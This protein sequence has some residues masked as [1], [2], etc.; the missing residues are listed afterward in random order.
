MKLRL[1]STARLSFP[2]ATAI[3]VLLSASSAQAAT[4]YWD[5]NG[6][7]TAGSGAATGTWGTSVFW[8]TDSTGANVGSP[9]LTAT[10]INADDLFFSAG[11]NGTTGTVTVNGTQSAH[12]ITFDDAVAI[13][14]SGGTAINLGSATV[15]SGLSFTGNAANTISTGIILNSAATAVAISNSTASLQTIGTITGSATTGTQVL[16]VGSSSSGGITLNSIGD[17][18]AGGNVALTVNNSGAGFVT[19]SG[20]N[21]YTGTTTISAGTLQISSAVTNG[22]S[23]LS[24][25]GITLSQGATLL[26]NATAGGAQSIAAPITLSG[27]AGTASIK[28]GGN[29]RSVSLSGGITG[30]AGVSQTLAIATGAVATTSGDRDTFNFNGVIANG[31]SGG[32]LGVSID[33]A[34][35]S[36]TGQNAFVNLQGQNTF[37]GDLTVT[38]TKGMNGGSTYVGAWVTIGGQRYGVTNAGATNTVGQTSGTGFLGSGADYSGNISLSTGANT[39]LTTLSFLTSAN[40]ILRG[41]ISGGGAL[42]QDGTGSLTLTAAN[43]FTGSTTVTGGKI[44]M[45]NSLALENS[46]YVTTGSTGAIGLDVT[47][48]LSSGTLT[49]GGLS[50]SV[51]LATAI[52]GYTSV[53]NL[54][55]NPQGVQSN[56]YSGI[57]ANGSGNMALTK[58][59]LGNQVLSGANTYSGATTIVAGILNANSSSALGNGS[60]TNTLIFTGGTLQAGGAITSA[61]TRGVTLTSTGVIDT[62]TFAV[63]IAGNVTGAGDL[64]KNGTGTLTLSGTNN[65]GG[66]TTVNAGTLAFA[67]QASLYNSTTGSWTAANINVKPVATLAVNVDTTGTAGFTTANLNTLLANISVANTAAQG[68]QAGAILAIDTTAATF[69]QGNVIANSTG[70]FGGAIGLTKLGINTLVLDKANTYTGAT[71]ISAGTLQIGAGGTTGSLSTSSSIFNNGTLTINRS[72]AVVQGTDFSSAPITGTGAFIQNNATGTTTLN[73]AN[74]FTGTTTVS[75]GVLTLT[76][77]L[78]L[79]NSALVTTGAANSVVLSGVTT[80]TFG[81]LNGAVDLATFISGYNNVTALTLNPQSGTVTYSGIIANSGMT[82]TKTGAGT[83]VLS[84]A[85]TYS[86]ATIVNAGVLTLGSGANGSL[87]SLS[88]LQVGSG[89]TF[90]YARTGTGQ[91]LAGLTV[92]P[93]SGIINNTSGQVLTL[94]GITRAAGNGTMNFGTTTLG[95]I[96][97]TVGNVN[98]MIGPWATTGTTTTLRYA[99]GSADGTT[100]TNIT[101]LTGTTATA[102][103]LANV[104]DATANFE[105]SAAATTASNLTAN[106]LRYSGAAT[107]TAIGA[108]NSLTLNGLMNAGSAGPFVISGGAASGGLIIGSTN[109]LVIAAN[110]QATTISAVIANGGSAGRLVYSGG[111]T[112]TLSGNNTFSGGLVINAGTVSLNTPVTSSFDGNAGAG[113]ITVNTGGTLQITSSAITSLSRNMTLNGGIF[114]F[115][116]SGTALSYTGTL[117]LAANSSIS[118]GTNNAEV[119]SITGGTSGAGGLTK[120]GGGV[121]RLNGANTYTGPTVVSAGGLTVKSSLYGNDTSKWTPANI[122]VASGAALVLNVQGSGEFTMTQAA[123]MFSQ[124]ST[125]VNNNGLLAG[126]FIGVE[127]RNATAGTYVYSTAITDSTGSGGG[128]VGFKH[129]GASTTIVELTGANTYSGATIVDGNGTL[130]VSSLNSVF[131]NAALGTVHS[132]SSSLGA[133]TTVA[134]GTIHLG[135][136]GS[137]SGIGNTFSGGSITY[138]GTGET[139]DRVLSLNG[140]GGGADFYFLDQSGTG[141]LKF[142]SNFAYGDNRGNKTLNLQGSTGGT[143]ELANVLVNPSTNGLIINKLGTG[144]WTLSGANL[145]NGTTTLTGGLLQIGIDSTGSV[146][147]ITSGAIGTGGLTFNGGGLASNGVTARTIL[148]AVTFTGNATLGNATNTGKLTFSANAA[149]GN[150][151]RTLTVNS[152]AEFTGI[153]SS[154][155]A[156]GIIKAGNAIL[157]L[158]GTNTYSGTTTISAGILNANSSAALGSGVASNTLIFNGGTLQAGGTITSAS[159]RG[160]TMTGAGTIDTNSNAVSIAGVITGAGALTKTGAGTLTLTGTNT[161]TGTTTITTGILNANA[162]A[163]L[164]SGAATNTLIFNGGTLQASGTITSGS[165]RG[166]TMTGAGTIDTNSNSVSIAG[167]ITGAGALTKS[168]AGTLTLSSSTSSFDGNISITSGTLLA[169][170]ATSGTNPTTGSLGNA[171]TVSRTITIGTGATL[172]FGTDDILGDFTSTPLV[173]LIVNGGTINNTG[174]I[175]N[176]LGAVDLNAGTINSVGGANEFLGSFHLG[177]TVTVGGSAV[178]TISGSGD[179]SYMTLGIPNGIDGNGDNTSTTFNVANATGSSATDLD[180]S[181]VLA[182]GFS[183]VNGLIKTGVGT[184][185]LS[186]INTYTGATAVN[187]GTLVVNGSIATSSLTTVASGATL[188]GSGTVGALTVASGGNINPGNSPGILTVSGNYTQVGLYTAEITGLTAGTQHDQISVTGTVDITGGSLT[189][190]FSA[191]SY[192]A[193]NLIFIL[194]NDGADAITGTYAGLTQGA[195]VTNYGGFNWNISYVAN[196]AGTSFTGGNDIALMAVN[197]IPEPSTA[198]LGALG[199][200][201]L[202]RRRR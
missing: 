175:F 28:M 20:T 83:Q 68:L 42:R 39:G 64:A 94:G 172:S 186:S 67:N 85:N 87:N 23:I 111:A 4:L 103:T 130:R 185:T 88:A 156:F 184:M 84:G 126:S 107:T 69:T 26:F 15:G 72:D 53:T 57:I 49:L 174:N 162:S 8:T 144:T 181:A 10:T 118:A 163:A 11:T 51:A 138:T 122:T 199:V 190:A 97:T 45:T 177:G 168:N 110:A 102:T 159:T 40:Q 62:N 2:L 46:A 131:T 50:G 176:T 125:G 25:N 36:T 56:T 71:T 79:Q 44:F 31:G 33:F 70:T 58:T 147:A 170:G 74:T 148:N 48:G 135:A 169:T 54:T 76:N 30:Q 136:G 179:N 89:G 108:T 191:G 112:L 22:S 128:S 9:V 196:S 132:A 90:N 104:T 134:N 173:K 86:G 34:G 120:I 201:L 152:D 137:P 1:L 194:L 133:P 66:I 47:N 158:S 167:V 93:G 80:P 114:Q 129:I 142:I 115:S 198:F 171:Q 55:L 166:V 155:G 164:G 21:T 187:A 52:T 139:T 202:L 101:A 77:A 141:N 59:G 195:T 24:T 95:S 145:Y 61:S 27:G 160:V 193:N 63:S 150:A 140:G 192:A 197:P 73:A 75:A 105:Y 99:V 121:L 106:T 16:T 91:T 124:L 182:N 19:L 65:Y 146:G 178:S 82:L 183:T 38:N 143:G 41:I 119:D 109:E 189:A 12:S 116:G 127:T 81:G 37:T 154:T 165:T 188:I 180:V 153:V 18:A 161:Y 157:T 200:M 29:D 7:G 92:N 100:P 32:I 96:S 123:T 6:T 78:A 43:T 35:S 151:T 13:T 17:G 117:T 149:L 98:G 14:L 3:V 113:A 5:T 60:S